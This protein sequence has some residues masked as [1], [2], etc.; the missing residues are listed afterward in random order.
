MINDTIKNKFY[1]IQIITKS[2]PEYMKS[3]KVL[4]IGRIYNLKNGEQF[5][6]IREVHCKY[7]IDDIQNIMQV[8]DGGYIG[9]ERHKM[10]NKMNEIYKSG[11]P[12]VR[13]T[14]SEKEMMYLIYINND[15]NTEDQKKT[16][17]KVLNIRR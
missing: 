8:V 4:K 11:I 9:T 12:R 7:T 6:V 15:Y 14:E 2:K 16:L 17:E 1:L 13:F 10:Y 3:A 5:R